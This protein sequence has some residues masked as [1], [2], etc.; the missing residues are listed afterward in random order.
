MIGTFLDKYEVLQKIGEGG[1]ATVYR[2]RHTT[3]DR[4]VAIKV[5][6]PHLSSSTRNRKR[7]A[8][9]ARA[10][11]HLRHDNILEI[12]D[13]SGVET[14]DCYIITE[15][16]QGE[17]LTELQERCR[18][19]PSEATILLGMELAEALAYAHDSGILH[20]DLKPDNVM[21]RADGHVKLMDF[22]IARFLDESQVTL[23]GALVGSPAFMSPEQAREEPLD[24][25]SDLFSLGT[26]LF[27]LVTGHLP[28]AGSNPSLILRKIIEGD[29]P[30]VTELAPAISA[31]LADV[32]ERL[33][34]VHREARFND[35]RQ[36]ADALAACLN[37]LGIDRSQPRWALARY[38]EEPEQWERDLEAFL[39]VALIE[40]GRELMEAGDPLSSLRMLNR[41]LSMDESNEEALALVQDFH[42]MD[43][44]SARWRWLGAG[45][46]AALLLVMG[47][48]VWAMLPAPEIASQPKVSRIIGTPRPEATPTSKTTAEREPPEASIRQPQI[49]N[50]SG[51]IVAP[52]PAPR[53][54]GPIPATTVV[55]SK[56]AASGG[57][58]DH[59]AEAAKSP[60]SRAPGTLVVSTEPPT[61]EP[62][63]RPSPPEPACIE[64]R[65]TTGYA[66]IYLGGRMLG[67]TRD[68]D[69]MEV[70]AGR[71]ELTLRSNLYQEA[72]LTLDLEPGARG[73]REMIVLVR[74]PARIIFP[75]SYAPICQVHLDGLPTGV[76]RERGYSVMVP[77]PD[78]PHVVTLDCGSKVHKQTTESLPFPDALFTPDEGRP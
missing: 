38:V 73:V 74:K 36:V 7:F 40:R 22:G 9:E 33:L 58:Q 43:G 77:H 49:G 25:R 17:T 13:Y 24:R 42:G 16:V 2:G 30:N 72:T 65:S 3:L 35:A 14:Q 27:F 60:Q 59:V 50:P 15:F 69:C 53:R 20:R 26:L 45:L 67:H 31:S 41:L 48:G 51:A 4:D 39:Q 34:S 5:L 10:I 64:V 23:T 52:T 61:L 8:R 62:L 70:P 55:V 37:E 71:V 21:V 76:L 47:V 54:S 44:T 12:F 57:K 46:A 19:M 11:E 68:P 18:R 6:H 29:R 32:I 1:M 56:G 78:S 66:D 63:S 28:F 75:K